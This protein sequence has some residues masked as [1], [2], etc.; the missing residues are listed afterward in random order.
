MKQR[1]VS[2]PPSGEPFDTPSRERVAAR[3]YQHFQERGAT[4]GHD[5]DDWLQAERELV[6]ER[7]PSKD[8]QG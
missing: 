7:P 2:R 3:A 1:D 4:D 8:T 6:A 5:L